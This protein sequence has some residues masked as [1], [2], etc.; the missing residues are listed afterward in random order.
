M[1]RFAHG[2]AVD[3]DVPADL[4]NRVAD[5][6]RDGDDETAAVDAG[7]GVALFAD[8]HP[9]AVVFRLEAELRREDE[10]AD[11]GEF[12]GVEQLAADAGVGAFGAGLLIDG[13]W[14]AAVAVA[15]GE[16]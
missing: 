4:R 14:T 11:V 6:F 3:E 5:G 12:D 8:E 15:L 9:A 1:E 16:F 7:D 13:G 10:T 2:L